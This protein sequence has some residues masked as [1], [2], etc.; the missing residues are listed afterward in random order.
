ALTAE[1][2]HRVASRAAWVVVAADEKHRLVSSRN[3]ADRAVVGRHAVLVM[4]GRAVHSRV[5]TVIRDG[6]YCEA[7]IELELREF[8]ACWRG[9]FG[10]YDCAIPVVLSATADRGFRSHR[11]IV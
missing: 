4:A 5:D 11:V 2:R 10:T 3:V 9:E 1:L 7:I 8:A 6:G